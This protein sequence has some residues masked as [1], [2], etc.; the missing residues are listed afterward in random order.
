MDDTPAPHNVFDVRTQVQHPQR[1]ES[2]R[3]SERQ[4]AREVRLARITSNLNPS[5]SPSVATRT[6]RKTGIGHGDRYFVYLPGLGSHLRPILTQGW[7][8]PPA[9]DRFRASLF[10][11]K[12]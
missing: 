11:G 9:S 3:L 2:S 8:N 10:R 5:L 1:E 4:G 6:A 7:R 12:S